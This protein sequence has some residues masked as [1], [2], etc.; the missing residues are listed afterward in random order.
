MKLVDL[1]SSMTD[2]SKVPSSEHAGE[3]GRTTVRSRQFGEI[4]LRLVEYSPSYLGDHWCHKGHLTFVV[5]GQMVIEHEDGRSLTIP[6]GTS[7]HVAD[8]CPPH[9]ARSERGATVFIVD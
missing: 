6:A 7:Y 2:W 9:R 5:S 1:P 3:S 8:D 4:Q